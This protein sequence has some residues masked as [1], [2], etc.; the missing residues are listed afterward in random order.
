VLAHVPWDQL[1]Q[2]LYDAIFMVAPSLQGMF[3]RSSVAMGIKMVDMIDSM[4]NN[5]DD[6]SVLHKKMEGLGPIHHRNSVHAYEHMPV[7]ETVIVSLLEATL[8]D[9]FTQEMRDGWKWL[10]TWLTESMNVV[11]Q[12]RVRPSR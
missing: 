12:V 9:H 11:E 10:W 5:V 8:K 1:G 2:K 4:V 3:S 6:M 7:F